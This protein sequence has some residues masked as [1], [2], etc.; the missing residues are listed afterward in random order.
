MNRAGT[1]LAPDDDLSA[2]VDN[3]LDPKPDKDK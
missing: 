1:A 3:A 2:L